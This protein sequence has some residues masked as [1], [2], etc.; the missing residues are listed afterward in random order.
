MHL[1]GAFGLFMKLTSMIKNILIL[2]TF[3]AEYHDKIAHFLLNGR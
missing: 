2:E 3:F 1:N